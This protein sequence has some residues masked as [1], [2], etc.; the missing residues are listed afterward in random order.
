MKKIFIGIAFC[1]G[2]IF[3]QVASASIWSW[4]ET[5][6]PCSLSYCFD[7]TFEIGDW[8]TNDPTPNPCFNLSKCTIFIS[9]KHR[10]DGSSG[11]HIDK[12]WDSKYHDFI[13]TAPTMGELGKG[14]KQ[15]FSFPYTSTTRHSSVKVTWQECVGIFYA[16][17]KNLGEYSSAAQLSKFQHYSLL[18]N[19]I[20]GSAPPPSG[21][22]DFEQPEL[23]LDHGILNN[24]QLEGNEVS[25]DVNIRCTTSQNLSI[26]IFSADKIPLR[27]DGSLYST[28]YINDKT[29]GSAG[30]AL[31]VTDRATVSIKSVLHTQGRVS[32]GTFSGSTVLLLTVD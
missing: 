16:P 26:Y 9:H 6:T 29:L 5:T 19:S 13:L 12:A 1:C 27:D 22:C 15:I 28:L 23:N 32:G 18:P 24:Q 30:F 3:S 31:E 20:C 14:I 10:A 25:N 17:G 21:S 4:I 2:V 7:Y 11:Y 8:D